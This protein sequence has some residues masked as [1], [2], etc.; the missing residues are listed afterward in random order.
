MSNE[1]NATVK[2]KIILSPAINMRIPVTNNM[3]AI[4]RVYNILLYLLYLQKH[5]ACVKI[6]KFS[7]FSKW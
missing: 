7:L 2:Q 5:V 4:V 1:E 3:D 6:F